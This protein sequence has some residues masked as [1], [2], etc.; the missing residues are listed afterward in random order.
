[1]LLRLGQQIPVQIRMPRR[2]HQNDGGALRLRVLDKGVKR[3]DLGVTQFVK[4]LHMYAVEAHAG[5]GCQRADLILGLAAEG[6]IIQH[7]AVRPFD[8]GGLV[9][10]VALHGVELNGVALVIGD[11]GLTAVLDIVV[12]IALKV[13]RVSQR[14]PQ[15]DLVWLLIIGGNIQDLGQKFVVQVGIG[16]GVK[17][18]LAAVEHPWVKAPQKHAGGL[19]VGDHLVVAGHVVAHISAGDAHVEEALN[20]SVFAVELQHAAG[21]DTDG[22]RRFGYILCK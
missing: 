1:M 5:L 9:I 16:A 13:S 8:G 14:L 3:P 10:G 12:H 22:L 20:T 15:L 21:A 11:G 18:G 17:R 19:A 2:Q 4:A 7:A 6:N